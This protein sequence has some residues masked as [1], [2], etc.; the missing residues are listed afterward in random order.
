MEGLADGLARR[1]LRAGDAADVTELMAECEALDLGDVM[2][3]LDDIVSDWQ[4]PSFELAA[5]TVGVYDGTRLLAYGEVY[6]GRRAEVYVRPEAR[7]RGIG[8][9]LLR[10]TWRRA[11]QAG[12]TLVGQ[13][14][15][16]GLTGAVELFKAHGYRPLWTSWVL[17]LPAGGDIPVAG[18]PAGYAIRAYQAGDERAV[19][20]TVEDAFNEWP[21]RDP[22]AYE[23]WAAVVLERPG[24][25]PWQLLVVTDG[26]GGIVGACH[27]AL[28]GDIGWINQVAVRADRRGLGLGRALLAAAFA[29]ARERG[30]GR[31]E[32][33]TDSRTG[34]LGLY[35]RVG[36]RVRLTFTHYARELAE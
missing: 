19:H 5:D 16:E 2:I 1:A 15:P 12:G 30:A 32:L 3:E 26:G 25:E 36:M 6:K 24:F 17:E 27:L 14:V 22:T 33:S 31:S 20:R 7:R 23:D 28:S 10:W 29:A 11:R 13:T 34:A 35:L 8:T 21:D 4:R 9:A 18:L